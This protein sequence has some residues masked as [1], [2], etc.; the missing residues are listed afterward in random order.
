MSTPTSLAF[1]VR[2]RE[3]ELVAPAKATPHEFKPLSD[4]DR[5]LYLQFQSPHYN[6][7]AHNPS[8][9]GTDPVM[10]IRKAI[11]QALVYYYPYA[12]RIRQ[13]PENKLVVDCTGEGVL[14][15]EADADVTLEQFGDPI[16]PPFPC[17]DEL[18]YNVP[19]SEGIIN[20]PLLIFQITRL[21][22]GGFILGFRLNHPMSDAIGIVQL[23][24]AIGEISRGAQA[25]SIL[26]VWQREF[27]CARNPPRVTCTHN[28]YGDHHELVLDPSELNVPEFRGCADGAAHRC[29]IIGPEELSNIRKWVPPHLLP[30]SKFEIIT[31]SLWRCY[32]IASQANPNEE[33]RICMLVNAR[34]KFNPPVPEG[35]YGNVLA[36][37]AAITNA[38]KLCLNSLGFALELIRHAKNKITEEYIRSLA[39]FIEITK[40]LPKGFQSYV[41]SD[42]TSVGFDQ[43]DY[44]WGKP[45]YT[46]P[47]KAM[48]DD[49]NNSGTYYLPYRNKKGERGTMVLISLRAPVME[50]FALLFEELTKHHPE[51]SPAEQR[52]TLPIRH[53]L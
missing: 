53:R 19:G 5:Q 8:M 1:T 24:S 36:L 6:F 12:G 47:S 50:R 17:A 38:R 37:P 14:F 22:C 20:T 25:P 43:V 7:Y 9:R 46:G 18:L 32:A 10:V 40:G 27:L 49:I 48:P 42:L 2:R 45:V 13:E 28:E 26:P 31:A 51:S 35:Y 21:E 41:V 29:F 3:P 11:S 15:I 39:D 16:Q 4:I 33:M 30:C 34:S 44:G 23:L 52:M